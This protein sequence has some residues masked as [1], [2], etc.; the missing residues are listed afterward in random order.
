MTAWTATNLVA[1]ALLPP[2]SLV[3]LLVTGLILL[4]RRLGRVLVAFAAFAL[5]ILSMPWTGGVLLRSLEIAPPL[6]PARLAAADAIVI[7]GGGRALDAPE[8][9][10]DTLKRLSLERLRYG[11]RL[12]RAS[13]LPV[14]VTGGLPG[15]GTHAEGSLM[16]QSLRAEFGVPVRWVETRAETTRDNA[17]LAGDLL[18]A[19]GVHRIVLVTHAWHLRRAVPGFEHQGF[20]IVPAGVGFARTDVD[21]VF[22][23]L[24]TPAGLRDSAFALHEWLGILWYKRRSPD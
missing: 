5:Y 19:D 18:R 4:P 8:Y 10:G 22:A 11:A 7:L 13:G 3:I 12:H 9:G 20:E 1:L 23:L 6:E 17:R 2:G 14:L 15:G 21:D 16:A 24:P